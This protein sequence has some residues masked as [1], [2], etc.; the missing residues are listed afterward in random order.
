[1]KRKTV[2]KIDAVGSVKAAKGKRGISDTSKESAHLLHSIVQGFSI[3]AF[4]IGVNHKIIYWNRA[5][6]R[7]TNIPMSEVVDTNQHW[8]AFY[9]SERPC[10]ADLLVDGAENRIPKWYAGKYRKS[11][12]LEE[13]YEATDF[14]PDR[15]EKGR[16]LRFTAALIR[17]ANGNI[18]GAIETLEDITERMT[19]ELTRH[20]SEQQVFS[21]IEGLP[22]PTYVIGLD[23]NVIYWNRALEKLSKIPAKDM[24]GTNQHWRAFYASERPC[25]SDLVVDQTMETIPEWYGGVAKSKLL[26][27]TYEAEG[28]FPDLGYKGRWLRFTVSPLHSSR[29]AIVG[30][31]ET[32]EDIT[33][34][35]LTERIIFDSE[36]ILH[37]ILEGFSIAAFVIDKNHKILYWNRALE[38]L[39]RVKAADVRGTDQQWRAFYKK[40]R[41]CMADMLVDS[42]LEKVPQWYSGKYQKSD[43]IEDAYEA[44]DFFPDLGDSGCWL[45]FTAALIRDFQGELIGAVETLED[46]TEQRLAEDALK[47]KGKSAS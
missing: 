44:T 21:I 8:R 5:L 46:I 26:E 33:E 42:A 1:M 7:M 40:A 41:P 28:F 3:P 43:L 25:M 27:D 47:R 19:A 38:K 18:V 29:G 15:G 31:I 12:L 20:E 30:C 16:W 14:F 34:R 37:S 22:I 11:E 23:H 35:E 17:Q 2:E 39:T 13:A 45:R 36:R 6:E 32:L 4:V 9:A 24:I 10:M